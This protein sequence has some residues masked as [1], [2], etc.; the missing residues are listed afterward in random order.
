MNSEQQAKYYLVIFF[1]F[2]ISMVIL[3]LFDKLSVGLGF[4]IG[5]ITL[6]AFFAISQ[7]DNHW[8]W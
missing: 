7:I 4:G 5:V 8:R 2:L 3:S 1:A 6:L